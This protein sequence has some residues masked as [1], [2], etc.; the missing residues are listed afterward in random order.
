MANTSIAQGDVFGKFTFLSYSHSEKGKGIFWNVRCECGT[1]EVRLVAPIFRGDRESCGCVKSQKAKERRH[2][3]RKYDVKPGSVFNELTVISEIEGAG[4]TYYT[5]KCSCGNNVVVSRGNLVGNKVKS[6]GCIR[7][8][9]KTTHAAS[10]SLLYGIYITMKARCCNKNDTDYANYGGRGIY[11]CDRWLEGF[12]NF[13]DDMGERPVGR[14]LDRINNDGPYSPDNCRW[15]TNREQ[16]LNT[17]SNHRVIIGATSYT[18][19]E[20]S[21]IV[22]I[23]RSVISSRIKNNWSIEDATLTPVRKINR[24][25][26]V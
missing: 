14:S 20:L 17:R 1:E 25:A 11:V 2:L 19:T 24:R 12:E 7:G 22:G 3:A 10:K 18:L 23:S 15:A 8:K 16:S 13:R 4:T 5:C 21:E 26:Q 6:C 9:K